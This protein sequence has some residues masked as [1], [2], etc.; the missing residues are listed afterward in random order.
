MGSIPAGPLSDALGDLDDSETL[1]RI[2][3]LV[4]GLRPG[5]FRLL[6]DGDSM[7]EAG[8]LDGMTAFFRPNVRPAARQIC[9]VYVEGEGGTV[10][11]VEPHHHRVRLIPDSSNPVH[12]PVDLPADQVLVQGVLV[13]S[14]S[15][16]LF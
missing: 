7:D 1:T 14:F 16:R 10:K 15:V 3:D 4:P 6:I 13:A 11:R 2:E 5:D 9:A 12:V 8:L